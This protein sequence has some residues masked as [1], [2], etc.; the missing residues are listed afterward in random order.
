MWEGPLPKQWNTRLIELYV[1]IYPI[2][3]LL[4]A[5]SQLMTIFH[6]TGH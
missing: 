4:Y 3:Y 1:Q 2:P 5:S 6:T